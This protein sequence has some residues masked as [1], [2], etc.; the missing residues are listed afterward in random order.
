[1]EYLGRGEGFVGQRGRA[2][3]RPVACKPVDQRCQAASG[4]YGRLDEQILQITS[5][6]KRFATVP[7]P[8]ETNVGLGRLAEQ[9]QAGGVTLVRHLPL[10]QAS[11]TV[12]VASAS[13]GAR[14]R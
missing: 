13:G 14:R 11:V 12:D 8:F 10:D 9:R 2:G 5:R 6:K 3:T 4:Q 7:W 1:M